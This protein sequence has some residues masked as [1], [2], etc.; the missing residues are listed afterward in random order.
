MISFEEKKVRLIKSNW[1]ETRKHKMDTDLF[2]KEGWKVNITDVETLKQWL[3]VNIPFPVTVT[4]EGKPHR[5]SLRDPIIISADNKHDLGEILTLIKENFETSNVEIIRKTDNLIRVEIRKTPLIKSKSEVNRTILH[6]LIREKDSCSFRTLEEFDK[7]A[8][9]VN[10]RFNDVP[11]PP[12]VEKANDLSWYPSGIVRKIMY[13]FWVAD[14]SLDK[15]L[16]DQIEAYEIFR[17]IAY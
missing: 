10:A 2:Y 14:G 6:D 15:W 3:E 11:T 16:S 8:D 13:G 17:N 4:R 9:I 5:D 1:Y 7:A 12:N